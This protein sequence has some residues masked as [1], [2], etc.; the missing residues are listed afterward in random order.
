MNHFNYNASKWYFPIKILK[1]NFKEY[2][3]YMKIRTIHKN[4]YKQLHS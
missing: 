1:L 3:K 4:S 2:T